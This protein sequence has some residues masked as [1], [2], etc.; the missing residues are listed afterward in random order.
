MLPLTETVSFN[1]HLQNGNR[2]QIPNIVRWRYKLEVSQPLNVK[3][4]ILGL[5]CVREKFFT[6]MRKDGR[7]TI[8]ALTIT[9]LKKNAPDLKGYALEVTLS[10]N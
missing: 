2:F 1:T 7:I 8:P 5:M 10:P 6:K 9:M 3:V 4:H